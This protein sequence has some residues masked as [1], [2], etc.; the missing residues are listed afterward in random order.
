MKDIKITDD[1]QESVKIG[2]ELFEEKRAIYTDSLLKEMNNCID[3]HMSEA[4]QKEKED[5][6]FHSVYEYWVY[7]AVIDEMFYLGLYKLTDKEKREY[8][9]TRE[10]VLYIEHLNKMSDAY[11]LDNKYE[12]YKRFKKYYKRDVIQISIEGDFDKFCEFVKK[13]PTYVVK[14]L[15]Y[16]L[17]VGVHKETIEND[18]NLREIFASLLL[19]CR[20]YAKSLL[21]DG[22]SLVLEEPIKQSKELSSL[23]PASI[24]GIR[25]T[26]VR[27]GDKVNI[28]RPWIKIG[29]NGDFATSAY[30]GSIDACI[31]AETGVVET[32]AMGEFGQREEFHPN[33]GVRI[34]G[35]Q[36]PRWD[37]LIDLAKELSMQLPTIAYTGWDFALTDDGWCVIE[38]NFKGAFMW[39]MMYERGMKKEFEDMIGWHIDKKFWWQ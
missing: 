39:Q 13:H 38:G 35:F 16:G 10:K 29:V 25:C 37:E 23:H 12:A 30:L 32:L 31:N 1:F 17:G 36:I 11:I 3:S 6:F 18:N 26:T 20:G 8:I 4:G 9:T 24:N 19:E 34:K 28:Y 33:T 15:G 7:G 21:K 22:A 2:R 27:V 14:P 5:M